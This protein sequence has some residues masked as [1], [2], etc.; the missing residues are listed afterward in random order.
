MANLIN[1]DSLMV[2]KTIQEKG[3]FA[4]A[5]DALFKVPSAL[6]YTVSKLE[7]GLGVSLFDRSGHRA[8][9]TPAGKLVLEEGLQ[10]LQAADR[11]S[12]KVK[13]LES[14]W[15]PRLTIAIDSLLP[16]AP[17][18]DLI[19]QFC[20]L[21][22]PVNIQIIEEVLGG[23]WDALHTKRADIA[24]GVS[25][26][27]VSGMYD[28]SPIG[29]AEWV[30]AVSNEHPLAKQS[31][32]IPADAVKAFP[33]IVVTDSSRTLAQRSSGL[34]AARQTIHVS[35][36][37]HKIAAQKRGLGVGFLPIHAIQNELN[38][39]ALVIKYTDIPRPPI[40]MYVAK[41]KAVNGR[42]A[43]WFYEHASTINWM[44][45]A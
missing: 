37:A 22:K 43:Q 14:G 23:G 38:S 13:E 33:A 21:E 45:N 20:Q 5:A 16:C 40:P 34:F 32:P 7:Q 2:L 19:E 39:K 4:A 1:L 8:V 35:S 27:M 6:T 18:L 31:D 44:N 26:E 42:A 25:G 12:E 24:I 10:L 28:I 41:A 30:F 36:L 17:L 29:E 11:L 15:E 9:L 3:S